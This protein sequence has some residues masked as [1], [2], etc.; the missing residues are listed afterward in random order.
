[1]K[2]NGQTGRDGTERE[3]EREGEF[4]WWKKPGNPK[5]TTDHGQANGTLKHMRLEVECTFFVIYKT[6]REPTPHS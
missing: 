5:R 4:Q 6:G 3:R 2:R 1:M